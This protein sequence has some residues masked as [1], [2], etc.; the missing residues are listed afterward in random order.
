[1]M[2][3]LLAAR[4]RRV[5]FVDCQFWRSK[6]NQTE[7]NRWAFS[8]KQTTRLCALRAGNSASTR[9]M[10]FSPLPQRGD[11]FSAKGAGSFEAW[12]IAPRKEFGF[13]NKR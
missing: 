12:G 4:N 9:R 8:L 1:M 11:V 13:K 10:A 3:R 2:M 5:V 7:K 6:L